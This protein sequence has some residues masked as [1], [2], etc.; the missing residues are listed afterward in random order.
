[1]TGAT[2]NVALPAGATLQEVSK[3]GGGMH[4]PPTHLPPPL[5]PPPSPQVSVE[6]PGSLAVTGS[7]A[8]PKPGAFVRLSV[9]PTPVEAVRAA[10]RAPGG[11][12]AKVAHHAGWPAV[13][14]NG[15]AGHLPIGDRFH[16]AGFYTGRV[17]VTLQYLL[18]TG[19]TVLQ[20]VQYFTSPPLPQLVATYSDFASRNMW[21]TTP[22]PFGRQYAF[23][24]YDFS[25]P[26]VI[27]QESRVFVA[28]LSDEAGAGP[29]LAF[30]ANVA[31]APTVLGVAQLATYVNRTLYGTKADGRGVQV[32]VQNMTLGGGIVA[33]MFWG[34]G[35]PNYTY[36]V[37]PCWDEP[38]SLQS[39]WRAY[40]Y[41]HPQQI[42]LHLYQLARNQPW[43]INATATL[44]AQSDGQL[45][46]LALADFY[47][48][49]SVT[50]AV[51]MYTFAGPGSLYELYQFGLMTGS[52]NVRL[53]DALLEEGPARYDNYT[54]V[55]NIQA[56]RLAIWASIPFPFGSEMP[57]DSTGQEEIYATA[58]LWG[59]DT[60]AETVLNA[61]L[62]YVPNCPHW[63]YHG[64]ARRYFDFAVN[65][66]M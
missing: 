34:P 1:M 53:L 52:V 16:S 12:H 29:G 59:N 8:P 4:T 19:V 9:V 54:A 13:L 55:A 60:L 17:R 63:A 46:G 5:S 41:E 6:P 24:D 48:S 26:G 56:I 40:N 20:T 33:S 27:L 3:T 51:A 38:R 28:G 22:E 31:R 36:T 14:R 42:Y 58:A 47:L 39:Y 2:L 50:T 37:S 57:W 49:Q 32:S 45:D 30:A 62:A 35:M 7:F 18:S 25:V 65:G 66:K 11:S 43:L 10:S 23:L 44:A 61:V 21:Y 64:S 15:T